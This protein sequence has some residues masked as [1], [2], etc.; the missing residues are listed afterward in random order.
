LLLHASHE[1]FFP[2]EVTE[3]TLVPVMVTKLLFF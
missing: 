3:L 1:F 2:F